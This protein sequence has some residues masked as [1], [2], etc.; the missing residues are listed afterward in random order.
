MPA[1]RRPAVLL[2]D[3]L[4]SLVAGLDQRPRAAVEFVA[5]P[6][7]GGGEKQALVGELCLRIYPE[8]E[9]GE[10]ADRLRPDADLTVRRD[11]DRECVGSPRADVADENR[12]AAVDEALGQPFVER[13]GQAGFDLA[14]SLSPFGRL[15]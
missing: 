1:D 14:R 7:L 12:R 4:E 5:Q 13:V 6:A 10:M 15:G 11:G 3:Q 8:V 2:D 9:A